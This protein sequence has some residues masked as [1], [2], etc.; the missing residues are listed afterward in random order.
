L[1]SNGGQ[2]KSITWYITVYQTKK[3][4]KSHNI[5]ALLAEGLAYHF[6]SSDYIDEI[7]ERA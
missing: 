2:A 4:Q 6:D 3:Q 5:S 7:R 1:I